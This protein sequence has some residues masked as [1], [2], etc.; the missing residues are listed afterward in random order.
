MIATTSAKYRT[1]AADAMAKSF[2]GGASAPTGEA[3][4]LHAPALRPDRVGA[5]APPTK[6][7]ATLVASEA[8]P[9]KD[10]SAIVASEA[11]PTKDFAPMV[12]SASSL[13]QDFAAIFGFE[14]LSIGQ[15]VRIAAR[16]G[17]IAHRVAATGAAR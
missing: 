3:M 17:K 15:A 14:A 6:D 16:I 1:T 7:F 2:V 4:R 8:S 12:E 10:F 5:E 9:A 13:I 11:P